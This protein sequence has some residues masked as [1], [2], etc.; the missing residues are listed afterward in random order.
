MIKRILIVDDE[1]DV[2]T[3][4]KMLVESMGYEAKTARSGKHALK[5][6]KQKHFDLLL[7]DVIMP[8][9]SGRE[10]LENI[11]ANPKLRNQ[12]VAFLTLVQLG[13]EGIKAIKKLKPVEYFQ[14]PIYI[15]GFK[16]K[17]RKILK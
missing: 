5:L 9:M 3:S 13:Q 12:K 1:D 8:K 11:R 6:L 2:L 7:L 10:V 4:M 16:K 14:K 15:T 17:L